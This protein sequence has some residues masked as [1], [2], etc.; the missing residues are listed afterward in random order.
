MAD[1]VVL[2]HQEALWLKGSKAGEHIQME[3]EWLDGDG[4]NNQLIH[5]KAASG[6]RAAYA[7][8]QS[9]GTSFLQ[10]QPECWR[11]IGRASSKDE[12]K[13]QEKQNRT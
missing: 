2:D 1:S 13:Q 6:A 3:A 11:S 4:F 8:L 7:H 12:E 10:Q 5:L 9:R